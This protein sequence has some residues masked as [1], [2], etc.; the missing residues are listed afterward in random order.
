MRLFGYVLLPIPFHSWNYYLLFPFYLRFLSLPI[1]LH[2]F[3][4]ISFP[5]TPSTGT[6]VKVSY[7]ILSIRAWTNRKK[8]NRRIKIQQSCGRLGIDSGANKSGDLSYLD[9]L[10]WEFWLALIEFSS[11][12]WW[13]LF[14]LLIFWGGWLEREW[15]SWVLDEQRWFGGV[16]IPAVIPFSLTGKLWF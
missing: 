13:F 16:V 6:D 7:F 15:L 12:S 9:L 8:E 14:W 11:C 2:F 3:T 5:P 10:S 1:F 4:D